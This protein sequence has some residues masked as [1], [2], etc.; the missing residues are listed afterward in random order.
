MHLFAP[1]ASTTHI[2][3]KVGFQSIFKSAKWRTRAMNHAD[4]PERQCSWVS[5]QVND[6]CKMRRTKNLIGVS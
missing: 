1:R 4:H 2:T 3:R 5:I 6:S